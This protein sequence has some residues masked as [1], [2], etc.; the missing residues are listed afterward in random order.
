MAS[1]VQHASKFQRFLNSETGP[2]TVH[3]WAPVFKWALV[4][5]GLNDIQRPVEKL[6]GTQQ[7]ALFAT[8]AIWTRWAGFVIK[9]RNMLLAS[10]NFFLGGVAGYQL[11]R[12][13]N[14]RRDL[15]DSPMQVFNY[16][17][18]G[19]AAAVKEPEPAKN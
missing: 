17:L 8:G 3:F 4:A 5:A 15:G 19:D 11:L 16:I 7:I 13:V 12:I 18:N 14:Y 10:V 1:T 6:S 2:R 9:P